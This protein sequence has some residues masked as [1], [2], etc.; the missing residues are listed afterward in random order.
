MRFFETGMKAREK[1]EVHKFRM[2]VE[3]TGLLMLEHSVGGGKF[4]ACARSGMKALASV[5]VH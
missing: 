4:W 2:G 5:H 3:A 1:S